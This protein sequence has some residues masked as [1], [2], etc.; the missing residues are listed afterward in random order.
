ME[1]INNTFIDYKDVLLFNKTVMN[2]VVNSKVPYSRYKIILNGYLAL[3]G[4]YLERNI[5]DE[6]DYYVISKIDDRGNS[7]RFEKV[8]DKKT[9][10]DMMVPCTCNG[11]KRMKFQGTEKCFYCMRT[12]VNRNYLTKIK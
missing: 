2:T 7:F 9:E 5:V 4:M 3:N 12:D 8:M 6:T 1:T 11:V 10:L